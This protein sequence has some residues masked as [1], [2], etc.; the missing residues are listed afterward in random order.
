MD[1]RLLNLPCHL[2]VLIN[3]TR[4]SPNLHIQDWLPSNIALYYIMHVHF[5][6]EFSIHHHWRRVLRMCTPVISLRLWR[7]LI[8]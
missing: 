7:S 5:H 3:I 6:K 4:I 1:D 8:S 2:Q